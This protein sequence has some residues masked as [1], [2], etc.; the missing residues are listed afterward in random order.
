MRPGVDESILRE[1]VLAAN[2]SESM[3][4]G[5]SSAGHTMRLWYQRWGVDEHLTNGIQ[6][7]SKP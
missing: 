2:D 1:P 7:H 5:K 3:E 6:I 4:I